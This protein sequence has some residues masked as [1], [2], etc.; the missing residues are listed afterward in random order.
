MPESANNEQRERRRGA[1]L[2]LATGDALEAWAEQI[3]SVDPPA[4]WN[5]NGAY[6][7][8]RLM[9]AIENTAG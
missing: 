5:R 2:G 6:H 3:L 9:D 1:M 8:A 7:P 4:P